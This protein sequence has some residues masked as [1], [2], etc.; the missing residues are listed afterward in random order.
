MD[1]TAA[2]DLGR[3]PL[4]DVQTVDLRAPERDLWADEAVLWARLQASWTGLDDAAW[5]LPGAAPSDAGGPDWSLLDHVAHL[6]GWQDLAVDYVATALASGAWPTDSDFAGGD[7]DVFNERLRDE[8]AAFDPAEVRSRLATGHDRLLANAHRLG[9][10]AIRTDD[11]W[12]WVFMALHGHQLEHLAI[13]E[14]WVDRLRTGRTGNA[15]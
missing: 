10:D 1:L 13:I 5:R 8:W 4:A 11:A 15:G 12:S 9:E 6:A 2:V 14:P 7:F 3:A